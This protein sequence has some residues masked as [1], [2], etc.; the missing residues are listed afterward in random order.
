MTASKIILSSS[1][2]GPV[3]W[4]AAFLNNDATIEQHEHYVKQTWR[5]R[6]RIAG[7]NDVQDL[8]IP[9]HARNHTEMREVKINYT[10]AWQRQHWQSIRSAY[11]NSPFF[12]FYADYF[13]PFYEKK[14]WEKL[15]DYN[16]ELLTLTLRLLKQKKEIVFTNEFIA[17]PENAT[18]LRSQISPKISRDENSFTPKRYLQVFEERHGFIPN[19]SIVD[20]LCCVGPASGE[21]LIGGN[22]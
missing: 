4:Y 7:P 5:N 1:Y 13:A 8:V 17:S 15:L 2:L 9:V 20:L 12:D 14:D 22:Y 16:S 21:I 3:Q 6:T 18:D 11:G 10:E 19:L